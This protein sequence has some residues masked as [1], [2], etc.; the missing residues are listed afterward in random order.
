M[1]AASTE[2][3]AHPFRRFHAPFTTP[4]HSPSARETQLVADPRHGVLKK[5]RPRPDRF[6]ARRAEGALPAKTSS[7][8]SRRSVRFSGLSRVDDAGVRP[9]PPC[10]S[11]GRGV[12]AVLRQKTTSETSG[13]SDRRF[14]LEKTKSTAAPA[15]LTNALRQIPLIFKHFT[16]PQYRTPVSR[17]RAC[18]R[19]DRKEPRP[20]GGLPH[21][22]SHIREEYA[23]R[24]LHARDPMFQHRLS[25]FIHC[26]PN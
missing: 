23:D 20:A 14:L 5:R 19:G 2:P 16:T 4:R 17:M 12:C 8:G 1:R 10:A 9:S 7:S 3:V 11:R 24:R 22:A 18:R 25:Q 6:A 21:P 26:C 13:Q 15:T